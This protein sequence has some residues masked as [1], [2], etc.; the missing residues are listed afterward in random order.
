MRMSSPSW[1]LPSPST[2]FN[3]GSPVTRDQKL[4]SHFPSTS[5]EFP[6]CDTHFPSDDPAFSFLNPKPFPSFPHDGDDP[7]SSSAPSLLCNP[8]SSQHHHATGLQ[9]FHAATDGDQVLSAFASQL[10]EPGVDSGLEGTSGS[11][12]PSNTHISSALTGPAATPGPFAGQP[13]SP[14]ATLSG[15]PHGLARNVSDVIRKSSWG[16]CDADL[17]DR[18]LQ[19]LAHAPGFAREASSTLAPFAT[20]RQNTTVAA[21]A[22]SAGLPARSAPR[23]PFPMHSHSELQ[24]QQGTGRTVTQHR[25]QVQSPLL[26]DTHPCYVKG[27]PVHIS[28]QGQ[29]SNI[30]DALLLSPAGAFPECFHQQ[31][32]LGDWGMD[33][34]AA[35]RTSSALVDNV[36]LESL[37]MQDL[38]GFL[39]SAEQPRAG[40][41]VAAWDCSTTKGPAPAGSSWGSWP[42]S[43]SRHPPVHDAHTSQAHVHFPPSTCKA[44]T[45][46]TAVHVPPPKP[47]ILMAHKNTPP[48]DPGV[49][50]PAIRPQSGA[51]LPVTTGGRRA[52]GASAPSPHVSGGEAVPDVFN[53]SSLDC[54]GHL[55]QK[56]V[57]Q[58]LQLPT[59]HAGPEKHAAVDW[60]NL[61]DR[62]MAPISA[63]ANPW[64]LRMNASDIEDFDAGDHGACALAS[65]ATSLRRSARVPKPLRLDEQDGGN[66]GGHDMSGS[67][68]EDLELEDAESPAL[69]RSKVHLHSQF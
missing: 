34:A 11:L 16:S 17:L 14:L 18:S 28:K 4:V 26:H 30:P 56:K 63:Q 5:H 58:A 67:E 43:Q 65:P 50:A 51:L 12:I 19:R 61:G 35:C 29:S 53:I 15:P 64:S 62:A 21:A 68:A 48:S 2:G 69:K 66:H 1:E 9:Q 37:G 13:A 42:S 24:A 41:N 44:A 20:D 8:A 55:Q 40:A 47:V 6:A 23:S 39:G 46:A 3:C 49:S 32:L 10:L 22:T 25:K 57:E 33:M 52:G 60:S 59:G 54:F 7:A 45:T 27:P 38:P 36:M 31:G